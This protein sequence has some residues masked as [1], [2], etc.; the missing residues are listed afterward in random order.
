M[1]LPIE[2]QVEAWSPFTLWLL[3]RFAMTHNPLQRLGNTGLYVLA[4]LGRMTL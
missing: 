1:V 3:I 4:D 2:N